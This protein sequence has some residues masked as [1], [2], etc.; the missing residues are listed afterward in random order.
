[1]HDVG[2]TTQHTKQRNERRLS[3]KVINEK[4]ESRNKQFEH[5]CLMKQ[6]ELK[7][8]LK[9]ELGRAGRT[10]IQGDGWLYSP[11]A[12]GFEDGAL[13][14][15]VRILVTAHL[16]T[17][18]EVPRGVP[19]EIVYGDGKIS[20]PQGIG[21]DDRCGVYMIMELIKRRNVAV[22]FFEDEETGGQGSSK[23]I[24]TDLCK[25]LKGVFNYVIELDRANEKDAVF[26]DCD[27]W[28]F[29][30]FITKE[31]WKY[32]YGSFS[33]I[34]NICPELKTAGVNLS[35]GYYNAHSV[36]EY[37]VLKEMAKSLEEVVKLIDRTTKEDKFKY[38][39]SSYGKWGK[40]R[41]WGYSDYNRSYGR[42]YSGYGYGRSYSG[43]SSYS[44]TEEY[45]IVYDALDGN[46]SL[47]VS[48]EAD[49]EEEAIGKFLMDNPKLCYN[50]I[51]E[52][53]TREE[54]EELYDIYEE[55]T[56][57]VKDEA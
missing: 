16:D 47:W 17:V 25:S 45:A 37:V 56:E 55:P 19:T 29:E 53:M 30:K 42:S 6:K 39:A 32:S 2:Y 35:V 24:K 10:V 9:K 3:M 51:I 48:V 12:E 50:D 13:Q 41:D 8:S 43:Y 1:M 54:F 5:Y 15:G 21:G 31:W 52:H 22:I 26:Y 11:E 20:S 57:D 33:D 28:D 40:W 18:H 23:F 34:S 27:S 36:K 46:G 38:V 7:K 49:S 4:R 14:E 44:T